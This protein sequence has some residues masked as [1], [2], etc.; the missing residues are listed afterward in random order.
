MEY[1][2]VVAEVGLGAAVERRLVDLA[3]VPIF[4]LKSNYLTTID[5]LTVIVVLDGLLDCHE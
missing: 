2:K 3:E 4:S 1:I 5:L